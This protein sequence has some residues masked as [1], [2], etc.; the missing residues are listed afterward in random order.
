MSRFEPIPTFSEANRFSFT[1]PIFGVQ[2]EMRVCLMLRDR[3]WAGHRQE[4]R[5]G[6]Q[7]CLHDSKCPIV[8]IVQETFRTGEDPGYFAREPRNGNLQEKHLRR[9]QNVIVR[10][11]TMLNFGVSDA[12]RAAIQATNGFNAKLRG[13]ALKDVIVEE[14]PN[15]PRRKP[16]EKVAAPSSD[17][18]DAAARGD[19]AA[20]INEA[21]GGNV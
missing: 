5:R 17:V 2:T 1:C 16:A 3:L 14:L 8:P 19:L 20:A 12:E 18:V 21:T 13:A 6:C 10:D 7:A 4:V 11:A 15:A 9:I